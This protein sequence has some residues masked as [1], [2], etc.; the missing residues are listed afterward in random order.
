MGIGKSIINVDVGLGPWSEPAKA[1]IDKIANGTGALMR[2]YLI[3]ATARAEAKAAM[4]KATSELDIAKVR[5]RAAQRL[6]LEETRKQMNMEAITA[7][8]L[9]DVKN[10]SKPEQIDNDWVANFFDKCRLISDEEMQNL[11]AKVLAGEANG[12]GSYSKRTVNLLGSLGKE[13]AIMFNNLCRFCCGIGHRFNSVVMDHNASIYKNNGIVFSNIN[14]L[15]DIGLISF[16]HLS[17]YVWEWQE[18]AEKKVLVHYFGTTL[19]VD[20]NNKKLKELK[21]G[22]VL[23]SQCG[24]ELARICPGDPVEG[25]TDY[26][27]DYWTKAGFVVTPVTVQ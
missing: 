16:N 26:L 19:D 13:D 22:K 12:P 11:W 23:L 9:P 25:F 24:Q 5:K 8:A 7:K 4:I 17:G 18:T 21:I 14:H 6:A 10:D 2:P 15:D 27:I 1:L 3:T 20:G